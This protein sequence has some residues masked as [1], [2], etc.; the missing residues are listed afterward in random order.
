[1]KKIIAP[2]G[3]TSFDVYFLARESDRAESILYIN[4]NKGIIKF[5]VKGIGVPNAFKL[6]PIL[7]ARI[8]LNSSYTSLIKLHNP[9]SFPL[10][11]V[12]IYTSD[13]D[14]HV[15]IPSYMDSLLRFGNGIGD[16]SSIL[17]SIRIN[18]DTIKQTRSFLNKNYHVN[19]ISNKNYWVRQLKKLKSFTW[20]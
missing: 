2:G 7:N 5:V 9:H 11:I 13:D 8:P 14:L 4:T 17:N 1:M 20:M 18:D 6:R 19:T 16:S 10:Q 3:N 15:E 12:E